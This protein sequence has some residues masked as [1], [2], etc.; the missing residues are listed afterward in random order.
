MPATRAR[1]ISSRS[2]SV[3]ARADRV[4]AGGEIPPVLQLTRQTPL[5]WRPSMRAMVFSGSPAR[6]IFQISLFCRAFSQCFLCRS[7]ALHSPIPYWKRGL[8]RPVESALGC[9]IHECTNGSPALALNLSCNR[10]GAVGIQVCNA[11]C[12][13]R[14]CHCECLLSRVPCCASHEGVCVSQVTKSFAIAC[15]RDAANGLCRYGHH[16]RVS[17]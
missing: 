2:A 15:L 5:G 10:V 7:I 17:Y 16:G 13:A 11:D 9:G 6:H 4:R 12:R 3:S 8:Q 1:D 14:T